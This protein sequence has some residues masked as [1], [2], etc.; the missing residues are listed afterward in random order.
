MKQPKEKNQKHPFHIVSRSPWPILVSFSVL[1]TV[2]GFVGYCHTIKNSLLLFF[3]GLVL[4]LS[5][6]C[7][8]WRDVIREATFEGKHTKAVQRGI[9]IGMILFIISEAM[10]FFA[11]FWAFFSSAINPVPQIGGVWPPA[12]LT[13]INPLGLPLLNT[14]ILLTSGATVTCCHHSIVGGLRKRAL[15]SLFSTVC[16]GMLFTGFQYVEY[17]RAPFSISDGIYGSIFYMLT[18]FHG[19][20][21]IVGTIFLI[22]GLIRLY[23]GHFSQKRHIG[24]ETAAWYWHFVDVVWIIVYLTFYCWGGPVS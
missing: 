6:L 11:F 12:G 22:V 17:L 3:S 5:G 23:H 2:I 19:F 13:P 8:W 9:Y 16:L 4:L 7:C 20:H 21:V 1:F 18:G 14:F 24:F 15:L 10:F